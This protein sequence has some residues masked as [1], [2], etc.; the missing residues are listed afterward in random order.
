MSKART[1]LGEKSELSCEEEAAALALSAQN[2]MPPQNL[3]AGF[4]LDDEPSRGLVELPDFSNN[5]TS[6][7]TAAAF[8][9]PEIQAPAPV[10]SPNEA[11]PSRLYA[12]M[13]LPLNVG[14]E[15]GKFEIIDG[16]S[17]LVSHIS[18]STLPE[19][20]L[21]VDIGTSV[22]HADLMDRHLPKLQRR[23]AAKVA[24]HMRIVESDAAPE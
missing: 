9:T 2:Q 4:S 3:S 23:L 1:P 16:H 15:L 22:Q 19:G 21:S 18:L 7:T 24:T 11:Q 8:Q 14:E 20:G 6:F 12:H 17:S 5:G 13:A 10:F